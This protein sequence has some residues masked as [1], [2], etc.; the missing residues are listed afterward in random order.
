[1]WPVHA[2]GTRSRN[3]PSPFLR[4]ELLEMC[5]EAF[6][7]VCYSFLPLPPLSQ[8]LQIKPIFTLKINKFLKEV[9]EKLQTG[10]MRTIVMRV[11]EAVT[12]GWSRKRQEGE[13]QNWP[14]SQFLWSW[15][16]SRKRCYRQKEVYYFTRRLSQECQNQL[17][18]PCVYATCGE[19]W[20]PS[21]VSLL[22]PLLAIHR[23]PPSS[24]SFLAPFPW[25]LLI[26]L[27]RA[28]P[29]V[30]SGTQKHLFRKELN[31]RVEQLWICI[32]E[33][34]K[35]SGPWYP[36][37]VSGLAKDQVFW[38]ACFLGT[39]EGRIRFMR[40]RA[41]EQELSLGS[42]TSFGVCHKLLNKTTR[43]SCVRKFLNMAPTVYKMFPLE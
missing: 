19:R 27:V 16:M 14:I 17:G 24:P 20:K 6:S 41:T 25:I 4:C 23:P 40:Q 32:L 26:S 30:A 21:P 7:F 15:Q 43:L 18:W 13:S 31:C 37:L 3:T 35:P 33:Q 1:M 9:L 38:S 29:K 5:T 34:L 8:N 11:E 28:V 39:L 12:K 42:C 10:A 2:Y 22:H 36:P